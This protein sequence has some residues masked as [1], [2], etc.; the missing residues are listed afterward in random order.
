MLAEGVDKSFDALLKSLAK[1]AK[2]HPK[3]ALDRVMFWR[4]SQ[5]DMVD[6]LAFQ[7]VM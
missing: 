4:Q 3:E 6:S 7:R 2:I 1:V 5:N